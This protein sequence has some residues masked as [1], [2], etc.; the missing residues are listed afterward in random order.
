MRYDKALSKAAL[1]SDRLMASTTPSKQRVKPTTP[2][3]G[4][5]NTSPDGLPSDADIA[6]KMWR[7]FMGDQPMPEHL[8]RK[9]GIPDE[10]KK[11]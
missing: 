8:R 10:P 5:Y 4:P 2:R 6:Q 1:L 11:D 9:Y 7:S 3:D